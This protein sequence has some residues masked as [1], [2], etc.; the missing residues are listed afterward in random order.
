MFESWG[1]SWQLVKASWAVL[2][3]DREL[4]L[5][6]VISGIVTILICVV[7]FIPSIAFFFLSAGANEVTTQV[8]GTI[9]TFI[10]YLVT[11]TISIY[12]NTALIGA[13]MIR[14]DGGDPTIQDGFRIANERLTTILTYAA[15]SATVGLIIRFLQERGGIIGN[16]I[17]FLGGVAWNVATFLV[18]PILVVKDISA[19]DAIKES[20]SLLRKTWGEQITGN[21]SIGMIFGLGYVVIIVLGIALT[22]G[23]GVATESIP[24]IITFVTLTIVAFIVLAIIQGA[25]NGIYQAALYRFAEEGVAPDAFDIEVLRNAFKPKRKRGM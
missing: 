18:I 8:F 17:A 14:L 6:P 24:L 16:I 25:L 1:R 7:M 23:I 13:A 5:F 2:Q 3:A 19:W 12:F 11:Y 21:F 20:T 22:F 9:G 10:F 4:L 15:M